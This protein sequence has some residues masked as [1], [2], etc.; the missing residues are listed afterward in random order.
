MTKII[1][2]IAFALL[3]MLM[4]IRPGFAQTEKP[5]GLLFNSNYAFS[6]D[7]RTSLNLNPEESLLIKDKLTLSFKLSFWSYDRLGYIFRAFGDKNLSID[8]IYRPGE[9][10]IGLLFLI[11]N[12]NESSIKVRIPD[13]VLIRNYWHQVNLTFEPEQNQIILE[14]NND[15]YIENDV[16][17][18]E[19]TTLNFIFGVNS[20]G[21]HATGDVPE[22][23]IKD[24]K[25]TS[26]ETLINH[27]PLDQV[28]GDQAIDVVGKKKARITNPNWLKRKHHFWEKKETI[29][30]DNFPGLLFDHDNQQL[31]IVNRKH[32]DTYN[33]VAQQWSTQHYKNAFPLP[34]YA[35][36]YLLD[37]FRNVPLAFDLEPKH[38]AYY[39]PSLEKWTDVET[40]TLPIQNR[41]RPAIFQN[42]LNQHI[43]VMS[44][45]GFFTAKNDL[46][47]YIPE[48]QRWSTVPLKGDLYKPRY[49]PVIGQGFNDGEFFL[50]GGIG[51]ASGKQELGLN[52]IYDLFLLDLRDSTLT[53][54]WELNHLEK[55][56]LPVGSLII[57]K[58]DSSFYTLCFPH[59]RENAT[60]KL[61][62]FKINS[63]QYEIVS[64]SIPYPYYHIAK[65][66][67]SL[68]LNEKTKEF[69]AATRIEI[70]DDSSRVNL[71]SLSYPPISLQDLNF[72]EFNRL[73]TAR[74]NR[75]LVVL[76][77]F[78]VAL[79]I[80]LTIFYKLYKRKSKLP[81]NTPATQDLTTQEQFSSL[82][83]DQHKR[84]HNS[85]FLF[86]GFKVIDNNST[87]ITT[88][89]SPKLRELFTI[90]LLYTFN[91]KG[92][93]STKKLT[94]KLWPY[95]DAQSAKN[96]RGVS[97]QRLRAIL[98][99]VPGARVNYADLWT[100]HLENNVYCDI[101]KALH[102]MQDS[103]APPTFETFQELLSILSRGPL[104]P[105]MH[106][107]W[108][109]P[110]KI[111]LIDRF[112][113]VLLQCS[114][115]S[116]F[117]RNSSVLV[118]IANTILIHDEF[119]DDALKMKILALRAL[120]KHGQARTFFDEF[121]DRY[122]KLYDEDYPQKFVDLTK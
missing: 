36:H 39:N 100:I 40:D 10:S 21:S 19:G 54:I 15:S 62:K 77:I 38:I 76:G 49:S 64:D 85:I 43:M 81:E 92:G 113:H 13:E 63:P 55:D 68:S 18:P 75:A 95:G 35:N 1:T 29:V 103:G 11:I 106:F 42:P 8:L 33:V 51:N 61:Y 108:L 111:Q 107:D 32:L 46:I 69:I 96:A 28:K 84:G 53:K 57:D 86:G 37:T 31:L 58:K 122:K 89:F 121:A 23:A 87:D 104:L 119:N 115:D 6:F 26:K 70:N 98:E 7:Q 16:D 120:E 24:I 112:I 83:V 44:G 30:T 109:D 80:A 67:A 72:Q 47:S 14:F 105:D 17:F 41:W 9:I 82:F 66:D 48:T 71:Y 65:F 45:Y 97:V 2:K 59:I 79:L 90:I 118:Q 73:T 56:L 93:I 116:V 20:V 101:E 94:E 91:E 12:G 117:A 78:I 60:L 99:S 88:K 102:I 27:W 4:V 52:S 5:G 114:G 22:M 3:F 34:D 25:L 110:L 50:F 74:N